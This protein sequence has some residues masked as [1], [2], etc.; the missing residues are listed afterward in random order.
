MSLTPRQQRFV[1]EYL[2]DL[3]AT[4]AAIRSGYSARTAA[5]IGRQL[6]RKTPVAEQIQSAQAKRSERVQIDADDVLRRWIE[7]ANADPN[8]LIQYRRG[9]CPEC[10][11]DVTQEGRDRDPNPLCT[12][13]G[14]EGHGRVYLADTRKLKGAAKKLYAGVQLGKDGIKVNMRDQDAAV[15]NIARHLGMFKETVELSGKDGGPIEVSDARD[16]LRDLL[17]RKRAASGS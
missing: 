13:C 17:A 1:D 12:K 3:N 2:I 7:I 5:D 9:C 8:D 6:L 15:I 16:R 11:E 4:Q 14:G 10:W